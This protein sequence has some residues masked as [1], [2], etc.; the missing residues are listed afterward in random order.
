MRSTSVR[1][2]VLRSLPLPVR[3]QTFQENTL[4]RRLYEARGFRAVEF[5]DGQKNEE[6]CPDVLYERQ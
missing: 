4:A 6:H 5:T 2:F 3:L 1:F